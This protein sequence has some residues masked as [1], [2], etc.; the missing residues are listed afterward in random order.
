MV[1]TSANLQGRMARIPMS[2]LPKTFQDAVTVTRFLNVRYLWIDSFC[3]LQDSREE[4]EMQSQL[5]FLVYNNASVNIAATSANN[6]GEGFLKDRIPGCELPLSSVSSPHL[7]RTNLWIRPISPVEKGCLDTRAWVLQEITFAPRTLSFGTHEVSFRCRIHE[8][9]ESEAP[10]SLKDLKTSIQTEYKNVYN[11]HQRFAEITYDSIILQSQYRKAFDMWYRLVEVYSEK[12]LTFATDKLPAIS[13]P[14]VHFAG[15]VRDPDYY[16]GIWKKDLRAGLCWLARMGI[17]HGRSGQY[18]A[19]SWSWASLHGP[20]EYL[21]CGGYQGDAWPV[22]F[23][24]EV[25]DV[26][27]ELSGSYQLSTYGQ[28]RGGF[29]RL[30]GKILAGI[31]LELQ[32]NTLQPHQALMGTEKFGTAH[33]DEIPLA[34]DRLCCLL[35]GVETRDLEGNELNQDHQRQICLLLKDVEGVL[36]TFQ[37]IGLLVQVGNGSM[38]ESPEEIDVTIQ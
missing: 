10:F 21:W 8:R 20:I 29:L 15:A 7:E 32:E 19:P 36:L 12:N 16:A 33:L 27:V 17:P 38:W 1:T 24:V 6:S 30:R 34:Q 5:M 31:S 23:S 2:S 14:A 35:L 9:R 37:R 28:V 18:I 13:G 11:L 22:T 25:L 26:G 3:I 4:W